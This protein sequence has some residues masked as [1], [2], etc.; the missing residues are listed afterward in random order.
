[1][2]KVFLLLFFPVT[3]VAQNASAFDAEKETSIFLAQVFNEF[4]VLHIKESSKG[5]HLGECAIWQSDYLTNRERKLITKKLMT[6]QQ[7]KWVTA[8]KSFLQIIPDSTFDKA[9]KDDLIKKLNQ[10]LYII[11]H[12]IFI[13]NG[14]ICIFYYQL[15]WS[16]LGGTGEL[17]VYVKEEN[18]WR[19]VEE[20][21]SYIN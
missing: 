21:C 12:P 5:S 17:E 7:L 18:S 10:N 13:R 2:K 14:T 9:N 15:F 20:H 6:D 16:N 3:I 8:D 11:S 19:K 4:R 1:M